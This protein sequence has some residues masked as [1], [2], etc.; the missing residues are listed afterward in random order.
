MELSWSVKTNSHSIQEKTS[1]KRWISSFPLI[2]KCFGVSSS[3]LHFFIYY[4]SWVNSLMWIITSM[5]EQ[6]KRSHWTSLAWSSL[7]FRYNSK[8]KIEAITFV[9]L[10]RNLSCLMTSFSAVEVKKRRERE[11][12]RGEKTIRINESYVP[13]LTCPVKNKLFVSRLSE[14]GAA[15]PS[16][17]SQD[18]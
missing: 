15:C 11:R 7:F 6:N 12:G 18:T 10:D 9:S 5:C 8:S 16:N 14:E 3:S 13:Y 2:C 17:S 4:Y 1:K